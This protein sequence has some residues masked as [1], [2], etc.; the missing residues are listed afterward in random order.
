MS[1]VTFSAIDKYGLCDQFMRNLSEDDLKNA[2]MM[3]KI[4]T[5]SVAHNCWTYQLARKYQIVEL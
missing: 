4:V 1:V 3:M 2:S 5:I